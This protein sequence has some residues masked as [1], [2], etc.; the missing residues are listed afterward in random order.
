MG[1]C[2]DRMFFLNKKSSSKLLQIS[3]WTTVHKAPFLLQHPWHIGLALKFTPQ[4]DRTASVV[5]MSCVVI[6]RFGQRGGY[7]FPHFF[8]Y[9]LEGKSFSD[10]YS[11]ISP[12][13]S[14]PGQLQGGW[15]S[16]YIAYPAPLLGGRYS[17]QWIRE[18][19]IAFG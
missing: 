11:R 16:K 13:T 1:W 2:V 12:R 6:I 17:W 9:L 8:H 4:W 18:W 5:Q 15:K 3:W 19:K 14:W 7:L 10:S